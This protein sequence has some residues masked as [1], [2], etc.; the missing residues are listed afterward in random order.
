MPKV[1]K[2]L[3]LIVVLLITVFLL[4]PSPINSAFYD[5]PEPSSDINLKEFKPLNNATAIAHNKLESSEGV[6]VDDNYIIYTGNISK[7]LRISL[8]HSNNELIEVLAE[9][10]GQNLGMEFDNKG[11]LIVANNPQG[12]LVLSTDGKVTLLNLK[13]KGVPIRYANDLAIAK[14]GKIYFSESSTKFYG[15]K[16]SYFYDLLEGKPYGRL[17]MYDP[18]SGKVLLLLDNLYYANG[19]ALSK[20]EDYILVNETNRYRIVK[21]WLKG[22]KGFQSKYFLENI[23][24][25]P[26]NITTDSD[27]NFWLAINTTRNPILNWLHRHPFIKNQFAKIPLPLWPKPKKVGI[28][29]KLSPEGKVLDGYIDNSGKIF[30]VSSVLKNKDNLFIGTLKGH[31]VWKLQEQSN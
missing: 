1:S 30:S 22:A 8:D 20:N 25:F 28:I 26:D 5:T 14:D 12:L 16:G 10:G 7:I 19:V 24:G 4:V 23:P 31:A 29:V 18:S 13:Y 6:A 27:G 2:I 9:T 17:F 3:L 21:Y 11:N 15:T